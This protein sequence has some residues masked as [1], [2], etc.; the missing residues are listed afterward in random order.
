MYIICFWLCFTLPTRAQTA[1]TYY[2]MAKDSLK[3]N[4]GIAALTHIK[5]AIQIYPTY[6]QAH[7]LEGV[8]ETKLQNNLGAI[9]AFNK[10]IEYKPD[11][12]EAYYNR[13]LLYAGTQ[14]TARAI[15]DFSEVIKRNPNIP[16]AYLQR[17][18]LYFAENEQ[19][20]SIQ[21]LERT[22]QIHPKQVEPLELLGGIYHRAGKAEEALALAEKA[23]ALDERSENARLIR[24]EIRTQQKNHTEAIKDWDLLIRYNPYHWHRYEARCLAYLELKEWDKALIDADELI[25]NQPDV[26]SHYLLRGRVYAGAGKAKNACADWKT[27]R[28]KGNREAE[29]YLKKS[30]NE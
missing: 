14:E 12:I 17:G 24:A 26:A 13:G 5:K 10:A 15:A 3:K 8:I 4:K 7:F 19:D 30:C 29:N 23:L 20:K 18:K 6:P 22:L 1:E 21:D 27:A 2:Q 11:Y 9:K 28:E 16:H 25:K